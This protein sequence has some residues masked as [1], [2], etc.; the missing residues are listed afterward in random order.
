[1]KILSVGQEPSFGRK[2]NAK[3]MKVYTSSLNKGLQLL[4]KQVD[5]ILHNDN[6]IDRLENA[7]R[8]EIVPDKKYP[9]LDG[10][11]RE[12]IKEPSGTVKEIE[13]YYLCAFR[14]DL[15]KVAKSIDVSVEKKMK[16][17]IICFDYQRK[18]IEAFLK[19][20]NGKTHRVDVLS[21]SIESYKENYLL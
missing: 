4:N 17:N 12:Y 18:Y 16:V 21:D 10:V 5:I 19:T 2:P 8:K 9:F 11:R 1:M 3:E 15:D 14:F 20:L 7:F 13:T 6:V